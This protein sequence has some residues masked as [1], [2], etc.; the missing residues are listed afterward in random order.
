MTLSDT[1]PRATAATGNAAANQEIPFSFTVGSEDEIAVYT[2]VTAT[3]VETAL[4][5]TTDFTVDLEEDGAGTVTVL[6]AVPITSKIYVM[7]A[8]PLTQ[9]LDL[10]TGGTF[11]PNHIESALDKLTQQTVELD[12]SYDR[13]IRMAPTDDS[14]ISLVLPAAASRASTYLYFTSTGAVTTGTPVA[15]TVTFGAFGEDLVAAADA[16]DA[17]DDLGFSALAQDVADMETADLVLDEYG[18]T[19]LAQTVLAETTAA[20]VLDEYGFSTY[21]ITLVGATTAAATRTLL[22]T[23][24]PSVVVCY[25]GDAVC[26]D[27]EIVTY[28]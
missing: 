13:T 2:R 27:G 18:F 1:S 23:F 5:L 20:A 4:A 25:E 9:S 26:Y 16:G 24:E 19:A 11:N 28:S 21:F 17:L 3:G 12:D 14:S 7:R 6:A 15:S 8:T 10:V 22:E